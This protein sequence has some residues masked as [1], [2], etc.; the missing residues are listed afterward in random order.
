MDSV[1]ER[2]NESR[3]VTQLLLTKG[4]NNDGDDIVLYKGMQWLER[5]HIIGKVRG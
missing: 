1:T 2:A 5:R 3:N 4:D